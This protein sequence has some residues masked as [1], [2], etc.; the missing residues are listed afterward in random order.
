MNLN[1]DGLI[2]PLLA[3]AQ[4][5]TGGYISWVA[6]ASSRRSHIGLYNGWETFE[7]KQKAE[8]IT[9][10]SKRYQQPG[11]QTQ[12]IFQLNGMIRSSLKVEET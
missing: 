4:L 5:P 7:R 6:V 9:D 11:R 1:R 8:G 3:R 12:E 10:G 2:S